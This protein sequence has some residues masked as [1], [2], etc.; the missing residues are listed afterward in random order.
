MATIE[1]DKDTFVSTIESS[2]TVVF[3][4][5]APWCGPCRFFAPVFEAASESHPEV[6]FAKVNTEEQPELGAA[7]RIQSIPTL[8]VFREGIL[9]FRQPGA[10]PADAL[11]ELLDKVAALDMSEVR[12]QID[13]PEAPQG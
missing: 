11:D 2:D 3:D 9:V 1:V 4:F 8:L 10:L 6:R 12:A 13:Q 5:W 7:L